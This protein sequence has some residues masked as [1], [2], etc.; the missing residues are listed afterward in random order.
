ML[1][2]QGGVPQRA[3][4]EGRVPTREGGRAERI[5]KRCAWLS[6]VLTGAGHRNRVGKRLGFACTQHSPAQP[7]ASDHRDGVRGLLIP[8]AAAR[9]GLLRAARWRR[10]V[11]H[12]LGIRL[13]LSGSP[14]K[15]LNPGPAIA[16]TLGTLAFYAWVSV[17]T[18][19]HPPLWGGRSLRSHV[20][21]LGAPI[22][23]QAIV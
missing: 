18:T 23:D 2:R 21:Q 11:K 17:H 20:T 22:I 3:N 13:G 8:P 5:R 10:D 12:G 15:G 19:Y 6:L 14:R 16:P 4:A 7:R 9:F 1:P